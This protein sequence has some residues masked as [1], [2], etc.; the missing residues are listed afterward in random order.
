MLTLETSKADLDYQTGID[1]LSRAL[2]QKRGMYLSSGIEYPGRYTRWDFAFIDPPIELIATLE[3][4]TVRALNERGRMILPL[5]LT[6]LTADKS[7][8]V[9]SQSDREVELVVE[10]SDRLFPEEERS[11]Q[12]SVVTP[13]R[14]VI[15]S[16]GKQVDDPWF[17]FYGAFGYELIFQFEPIE[18]K[19]DH[20]DVKL[21]HLYLPD[22]L[23]VVDRRRET[24]HQLSLTFVVDGKSSFDLS[25]EPFEPLPATESGLA[26]SS[27]VKTN[28]TDDDYE[29]MVVDSKEQM[30]L[31]NVYELVLSRLYETDFKGSHADVFGRMKEQNP[32]PYELFC[33]LGDEV[34]VGTSPEMFVRVVGKRVESCPI[35]GTVRRGNNAI[36]DEKQIRSLLNSYKDEVELSMCTD[37]DRNDKSRICEPGSISLLSRRSIETYSSLFHTVDH[38][39]GQLRDGF[40]GLDAFLSHMW[41]VTLVGSPKKRAISLI[42]AMEEGNRHWYGGAVGCLS[43]NGDVSSC[44][45]IRTIHFKQ[46]K[47]FYRVGATLVWDSEAK[48]E[49]QETI[50]KSAPFYSGLKLREP[51]KK[52]SYEVQPI[53][54][55]KTA[56]MIDNEDSFVHTLAE[57]FRRFGMDVISYRAGVDIETIQKHEP[58]LVIHS[59]GPG[60][61]NDFNM[62]RLIQQVAD[63]RIPQFGVCLGLQGM[64]EAY[65]GEL[66][67]LDDPRQGKNWTLTHN[68]QGLMA[69]LP[70]KPEVAAY[71]AMVAHKDY[72]PEVFEILA[73]SEVGDVMAIQHKSLPMMSV[74]FHPESILSFSED[75]GLRMIAN[76]LEQL[77]LS[78]NQKE[79]N[80]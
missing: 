35:S 37:V 10:D 65:G 2:D 7:V 17:G 50:T 38:V 21:F 75:V 24:A 16:F 19:K 39:E 48:A 12:P 59:P 70:D 3:K 43:F 26:A 8:S 62:P 60:R 25:S 47:A 63:A 80:K 13:L 71:H 73:E 45:T 29:E 6:P 34:L 20:A 78:E 23:F 42:E 77:V 57:Y 72:L 61:P 76:V 58:D 40:T 33:Q 31:G 74:Q 56:V 69:G 67:Y 4:I 79:H 18:F 28:T 64:V 14:S 27:E 44:I 9:Q 30:K 5:L 1:K 53:A 36:E 22:Q 68:G 15:E 41:A 49:V 11:K 54:A 46:N 55:G 51:S 32:S 52:V 66:S